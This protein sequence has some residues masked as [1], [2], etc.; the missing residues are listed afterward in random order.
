MR[1][2]CRKAAPEQHVRRGSLV[3]EH[4]VEALEV[5]EPLGHHHERTA[6]DLREQLHEVAAGSADAV[7]ADQRRHRDH[8]DDLL[9][10]LHVRHQ[11]RGDAAL[12][13]DLDD[14]GGAC[15]SAACA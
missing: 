2:A 7:L 14:P 8:R 3:R 9:R 10:F 5:L 12:G 11:A 6:L 13:R 15:R 4:V 1:T